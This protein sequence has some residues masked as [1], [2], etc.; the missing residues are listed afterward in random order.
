MESYF[1]LLIVLS[2]FGDGCGVDLKKPKLHLRPLLGVV[3]TFRLLGC[4]DIFGDPLGG[5]EDGDALGNPGG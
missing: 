5:E 4:G 3:P 2:T 1:A